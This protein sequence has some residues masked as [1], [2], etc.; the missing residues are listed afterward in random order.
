MLLA[1]VQV[2]I[3]QVETNWIIQVLQNTRHLLLG[4]YKQIPQLSVGTQVDLNQP[5]KF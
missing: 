5:L 3:V 4:K 2:E 1:S